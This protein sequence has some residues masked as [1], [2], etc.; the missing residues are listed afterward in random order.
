MLDY[1]TLFKEQYKANVRDT[2]RIARSGEIDEK[3]KNFCQLHGFEK[4]EVLEQIETN[5][6]VAAC[7]AINP[8]KQNFYERTA[9]DFIEKI[10][11]VTE[12]EILPTNKLVVSNGAVTSKNDLDKQGGSTTAKTIDFTWKYGGA[13]FYASHKYTKQEGGAQGNQ[14][15]DLQAFITEARQTTLKNTYFIAIADGDFYLQNDRQAGM[16]RIEWL[17]NQASNSVFACTICELEELMASIIY[18]K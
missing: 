18:K 11:G 15:K 7:F 8:N 5:N 10:N 3:I 16:R 1:E 6:I 14:Y 17:K 13:K 4:E 9:G 2:P 12:F